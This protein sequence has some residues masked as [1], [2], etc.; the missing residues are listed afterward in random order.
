MMREFRGPCRGRS[1]GSGRYLAEQAAERSVMEGRRSSPSNTVV[2][3]VAANAGNEDD[4]ASGDYV[5]ATE[6]KVLAA[7][8]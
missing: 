4:A 8:R 7:G 1:Q 6:V 2:F 5:Y 3:N